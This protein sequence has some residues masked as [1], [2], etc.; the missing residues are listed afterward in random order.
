MHRYYTGSEKECIKYLPKYKHESDSF[1]F[2]FSTRRKRN[3]KQKNNNLYIKQLFR[4]ENLCIRNNESA[5]HFK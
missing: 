3:A 4:R 2:F 5:R 1:F